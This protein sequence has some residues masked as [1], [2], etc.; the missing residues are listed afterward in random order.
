MTQQN[1]FQKYQP[2]IMRGSSVMFVPLTWNFPAGV[3][4]FMSTNLIVAT[5]QNKILRLPVLERL[6]EIPP[7]LERV[8]AANAA[9][10]S[11]GP[12]PLTPL[13]VTLREHGTSIAP[14]HQP[15]AVRRVHQGS[16]GSL[17]ALPAEKSLTAS[18]KD[19]VTARR[20][21]SDVQVNPKF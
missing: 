17:L 2:W 1:N 16:D 9:A 18:V 3:F 13:L 10:T 6:L 12:G 14:A 7:T 4:V 8:A 11:A 19:A 15:P 20:S 5:L 21:L